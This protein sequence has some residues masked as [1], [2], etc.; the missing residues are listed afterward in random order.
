MSKMFHNVQFLQ[1][2]PSARLCSH[3]DL[4]LSISCLANLNRERNKMDS[5][6]SIKL[7]NSLQ[8]MPSA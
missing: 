5:R 7:K 4:T 8:V 3:D 1:V 6:M 2:M